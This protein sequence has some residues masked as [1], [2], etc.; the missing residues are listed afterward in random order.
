MKSISVFLDIAKFAD[1]RENNADVSRT[2]GV[3]H[4]IHIVLETSLGKV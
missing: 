4:V 2:Q 3:Y 1:F